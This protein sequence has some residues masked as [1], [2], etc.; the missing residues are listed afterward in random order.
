[1]PLILDSI[2]FVVDWQSQIKRVNTLR[3]KNELKGKKAEWLNGWFPKQPLPTPKTIMAVHASLQAA[4]L[5][6]KSSVNSNNVFPTFSEMYNL[7]F[8]W[9]SITA[10]MVNIDQYDTHQGF[11]GSSVGKES[12]CNAGDPGL[13]P[14]SGRST[15]EGKGYPLQYSGL[16]NSMD[17]IVYGVAKNW[18]QLIDFHFHF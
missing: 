17:C 18:T 10:K 5:S 14:G 2:P 7:Y 3:E 9:V 16:E 6:S 11:P 13:I 4:L 8:R 15:G 12:A 1:M